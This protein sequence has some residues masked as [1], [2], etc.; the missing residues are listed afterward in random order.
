M[1]IPDSRVY[2]SEE[3]KKARVDAENEETREEIMDCIVNIKTRDEAAKALNRLDLL[4]SRIGN[5]YRY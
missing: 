1:A 3:S 2:C 5:Y 4:F